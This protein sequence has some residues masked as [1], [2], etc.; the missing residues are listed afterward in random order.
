MEG[1]HSLHLHS[2]SLLHP[3][4]VLKVVP[5]SRFALHVG[6]QFQKFYDQALICLTMAESFLIVR[7]LSEVAGERRSRP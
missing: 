5:R 2:S 3:A 1:L 6:L 7:D 4:N